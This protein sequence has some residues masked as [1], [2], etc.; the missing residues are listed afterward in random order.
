MPYQDFTG[1]VAALATPTTE[2]VA[3][4]QYYDSY[5]K[6]YTCTVKSGR[7]PTVG[8]VLTIAA[9]TLSTYPDLSTYPSSGT[10]SVSAIEKDSSNNTI[11]VLNK[12]LVRTAPSLYYI[13]SSAN[14]TL[15][16]LNFTTIGLYSELTAA[17]F[18]SLPS[19]TYSIGKYYS[20][21]PRYRDIAN[22]V[23][24][25]TN[26][27]VSGSISLGL[28]LY[29]QYS[30]FTTSQDLT[31]EFIGNCLNTLEVR[32]AAV[33]V[34][35]PSLYSPTTT[36]D[37]F[38]TVLLDNGLEQ[39]TS[40]TI[41]VNNEVAGS[42]STAYY[43]T[44]FLSN[45]TNTVSIPESTPVAYSTSTNTITIPQ[46]IK[47]T[48]TLSGTTPYN[49]ITYSSGTLP[50]VNTKISIPSILG[51]TSNPNNG[52]TVTAVNATTGV[53]TISPSYFGSN[54]YPSSATTAYLSEQD[55][56][57]KLYADMPQDLN[58]VR[59][60]HRIALVGT[61][62]NP[63]ANATINTLV[64]PKTQ[65]GSL[66]IPP[67]KSDRTDAY[68]NN[69]FIICRSN[70]WSQVSSTATD[71]S[72]CP[73]LTFAGYNTNN[74][75]SL[76]YTSTT[77]SD[78]ILFVPMTSGGNT[79]I[80]D[81]PYTGSTTNTIK[82]TIGVGTEVWY[83]NSKIGNITNIVLNTT[84]GRRT[85]T[86]DTAWPYNTASYQLFF[87]KTY[88]TY[89]LD[90]ETP[91]LA[92]STTRIRYAALLA[93]SKI[94]SNYSLWSQNEC[95][96]LSSG[97]YTISPYYTVKKQDG[98][99]IG[100]FASKELF[101][102]VRLYSTGTDAIQATRY[103]TNFSSVTDLYGA[104]NQAFSTK[105]SSV[106]RDYYPKVATTNTATTWY[107]PTTTATTSLNLAKI[108]RAK[109]M[110]LYYTYGPCI[111][112]IP[113]QILQ[114]TITGAARTAVSTALDYTPT[115]YI[116][117]TYNDT[118]R[119][120]LT[121]TVVPISTPTID[122]IRPSALLTFSNAPSTYKF[123]VSAAR[124]TSNYSYEK[125]YIITDINTTTNLI[126][127]PNHGLNTGD[128]IRFSSASSVPGGLVNNYY[129]YVA[130]FDV[131]NIYLCA[132][133]KNAFG[134][135]DYVTSTDIAV[136]PVNITSQGGRQQQY[137]FKDA[138]DYNR[139][140]STSSTNNTDAGKLVNA[141]DTIEFSAAHSFAT[142]D[143]VLFTYFGVDRHYITAISGVPLSSTAEALT[144][145]ASIGL[146][147]ATYYYVIKIDDYK[148]S[149]AQ[150]YSKA[151]SAIKIAL[152]ESY[153]QEFPPVRPDLTIS[154]TKPGTYGRLTKLPEALSEVT[155]KSSGYI[156]FA[157]DVSPVNA[158]PARTLTGTD[159]TGKTSLDISLYSIN[160]TNGG[161]LN[162]VTIPVIGST[163]TPTSVNSAQLYALSEVAF[164]P[165]VIIKHAGTPLDPNKD[166]VP[167]SALSTKT[168]N[169]AAF[170]ATTNNDFSIDAG[171][172]FINGSG[173]PVDIKNSMYVG[174]GHKLT[175]RSPV[176]ISTSNQ[177]TIN[178]TNYNAIT[179]IKL[180]SL[181]SGDVGSLLGTTLPHNYGTGDIVMYQKGKNTTT[182]YD[183][184]IDVLLSGKK[185]YVIVVDAYWFKLAISP[186][187]AQAN[188]GIVFNT[189]G[190]FSGVPVNG[191]DTTT[192]TIYFKYAQTEALSPAAYTS[193]SISNN[194]VKAIYNQTAFSKTNYTFKPVAGD[195]YAQQVYTSSG[196]T[197]LATSTF[198]NIIIGYFDNLSNFPKNINCYDT[199]YAQ[200]IDAYRFRLTRN[201]ADTD[202]IPIEP[203]V[204]GT[205]VVN[206][207]VGVPAPTSTSLI[208]D[209]QTFGTQNPLALSLGWSYTTAN[210]NTIDG[211]VVYVSNSDTVGSDPTKDYMYTVP[212]DD[213]Y[214]TGKY[215]IVLYNL[216]ADYFYVAVAA[217][218]YRN[219]Y[220][221]RHQVF[222]SSDSRE[223]QRSTLL[224]A[225]ITSLPAAATTT[226]LQLA[227][228]S[229][230]TTVKKYFIPST[231]FSYDLSQ[232]YADAKNTL[233]IDG[234]L[235]TLKITKAGSEQ[236]SGQFTTVTTATD[237]IPYI[238][239][240]DKYKY[241]SSKDSIIY[242]QNIVLPLRAVD[243]TY[244]TT[245]NKK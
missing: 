140:F 162:K 3:V 219:N 241:I 39:Q 57:V 16:S 18:N 101:E 157:T 142:G 46:T 32:S 170:S 233:Y 42:K 199:Y 156:G 72:E 235:G 187:A 225:N 189:L 98:T 63:R 100:N 35:R 36:T 14:Y 193:S 8:T 205:G 80:V 11:L 154:S 110:E 64:F 54:Y 52:F 88:N 50:T 209:S 131:D 117:N 55:V 24:Y 223:F 25:K 221:Y 129:Y 27:G 160:R 116:E 197:A 202:Y 93:G 41:P 104:Y 244:G 149:L 190:S 70:L 89:T 216:P 201:Y 150:T 236:T 183:E 153:G 9:S 97:F 107:V 152:N 109:L 73:P 158:T 120:N 7:V 192:A 103:I 174:T 159:L 180:S 175:S 217:Y 44:T 29:S 22:T 122:L 111:I 191:V 146:T 227:D 65:D 163:T 69:S 243:S 118:V 4:A 115:T 186:E 133:Y 165:S 212:Y 105:S 45:S 40:S 214:T 127:I 85:V 6:R 228:G 79:F 185:Y 53:I 17:S 195:A 182:T 137:L 166:F 242:T 210:S 60:E 119:F 91:N 86:M 188:K 132:S 139:V 123:S 76:D 83:N 176:R 230:Y 112:E 204:S 168:F 71:I 141:T 23:Y 77:I 30:N 26:A 145:M 232:G 206:V 94:G 184:L 92:E 10:L 15:V 171:N 34:A 37:R 106:W 173:W 58:R 237:Y 81:N 48:G 144:Y 96:W 169:A 102:S 99:L 148:I 124:L 68:F 82:M 134:Y 198:N 213:P 167:Y 13:N 211:F 128:F 207:Y 28:N 177:T 151:L 47:F 172:G 51:S 194:P 224:K 203:P 229:T 62:T 245:S 231:R 220:D 179:K 87:R 31:G 155:D 138:G 67:A 215:G 136:T 218:R 130:V 125:R 20:P 161:I 12:P 74:S 222:F 75:N 66:I 59:A 61:K 126:T 239:T 108:T 21:Y 19:G 95:R 2:T 1:T 234:K 196:Q 90:P 78:S 226:S 121:E 114:R 200:I 240:E 208:V 38:Y 164:L 178:A 238:S 147:N 56:I 113:V 143:R 33:A 5:K 49:T 84:T 181:I 135:Y 43:T